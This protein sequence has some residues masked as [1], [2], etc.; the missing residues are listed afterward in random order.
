MAPLC[1]SFRLNNFYYLALFLFY[2]SYFDS[3]FENSLVMVGT[4]VIVKIKNKQLLGLIF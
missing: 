4:A 2:F 3:M 1:H